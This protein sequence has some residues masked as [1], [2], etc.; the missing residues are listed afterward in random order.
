MSKGIELFFKGVAFE[1]LKNYK[2]AY[3]FYKEASLINYQPAEVKLTDINFLE[4]TAD[5]LKKNKDYKNSFGLYKLIFEFGNKEIINKITDSDCL[6]DFA[7]T[8]HNAKKYINSY[9]FYKKASELGNTNA[10]KEVTNVKF[11]QNVA[12]EYYDKEYFKEAY[13]IFK[14]ASELGSLE[15]SENINNIYFLE[16]VGDNYLI[17]NNYSE[18]YYFYRKSAEEGN[19]SSLLK[20][21]DFYEKGIFGTRNYL[22]AFESYKTAYEN[23]NNDA[24]DKLSYYY[25]MGLHGEKDFIKA[26]ELYK[27]PSLK[28]DEKNLKRLIN[29]RFIEKV[30]DS[31]Y[32]KG[33]FRESFKLYKKAIELG[34]MNISLKLNDENFYLMH[35]DVCFYEN[36]FENALKYYELAYSKNNPEAVE[37]LALC[38]E[39]GLGYEKDILKAYKFY[40]ISAE[41]KS[42]TAVEKMKE[43]VFMKKVIDTLYFDNNFDEII[44]LFKDEEVF[45]NFNILDIILNKIILKKA[46]DIYYKAFDYKKSFIIY[47]DFV[48]SNDSEILFNLGNHYEY[49]LGCEKSIENAFNLYNKASNLEHAESFYK[50]G[51]FYENGIYLDTNI[52]KSLE[53]YKKAVKYGDLYSK[54]KLND[55]NFIKKLGDFHFEKNDLKTAYEYYKKGSKN[56]DKYCK[57]KLND[58]TFLKQLADLYF[59]ENDFKNSFELYEKSAESGNPEAIYKLSIFYEKGLFVYE[60]S[61]KANYYYNKSIE[62]GYKKTTKFVEINN[63]LK[64]S[65][66][67]SITSVEKSEN[68]KNNNEKTGFIKKI[69][70]FIKKLFNN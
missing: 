6:F 34:N 65:E 36:D 48:D 50:I 5:E 14:T 33:N 61:E 57:T 29:P 32:Q 37:K 63:E 35:G 17:E 55:N 22:K 19:Y 44:N 46:G 21:G 3:D 41:N 1:N 13:Y 20:L 70:L 27:L 4:K 28:H 45:Q 12:E 69:L 54:N 23:G 15:A 56:N 51:F 11:L 9:L 24:I 8:Y 59:E 39:T 30:A 49:G 18:A 43:P 64:Q 7:V 68:I 38:Y 16:K 52:E 25:E 40:K 60:D 62:A 10:Q 26:Y 47:S 2:R 31:Y 58:D 53:Y 42:Q 67:L 66:N